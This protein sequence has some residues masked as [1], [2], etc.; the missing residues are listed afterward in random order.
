VPFW[1]RRDERRTTM[2]RIVTLPRMRAGVA[3]S[4][5]ARR[6]AVPPLALATS[7][8]A[9]VDHA[10]AFLLDGIEAQERTAYEWAVLVFEQAPL[11]LREG[12]QRGWLALGLRLD[13]DSDQSVLGWQ[14][15]LNTRNT[16]LLGARSR[17]GMP[18]ELLLQR[19]EGALLLVTLVELGNVLAKA[20]WAGVEPLHLRVVPRVLE[21]ACMDDC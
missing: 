10:D 12:L 7:T 5:R 15:R 14:S 20:V 3:T 16:L 21:R 18:A 2:M 9:R 11:G 13:E 1:T 17:I 19:F 6:I 4:G 8:L